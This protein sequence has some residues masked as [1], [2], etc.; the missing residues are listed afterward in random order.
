MCVYPNV[1]VCIHMRMC[2]YVYMHVF[3]VCIDIAININI[4]IGYIVMTL[5]LQP[6]LLEVDN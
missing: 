4:N 6:L 2:L 5:V 1:P 3:N